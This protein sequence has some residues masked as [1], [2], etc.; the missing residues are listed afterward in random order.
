M[1][2]TEDRIRLLANGYTPLPLK[3]KRCFLSEWSRLPVTSDTVQAWSRLH[4]SNATG[5][6]VE[7]GLVAVDI[8]FNDADLTEEL[9]DRLPQ[10]LW[11][12]I[13]AAMGVRSSGAPGRE[14]WLLRRRG[15]GRLS[16]GASLTALVKD[17]TAKV[18][19]FTGEHGRQVGAL[20]WHTE[21]ERRYAWTQNSPLDTPLARLP[22]VDQAD[23]DAVV[24]TANRLLK[25][26]GTVIVDQHDGG[27]VQRTLPTGRV[28]Q[29][30]RFGL[31]DLKT[32]SELAYDHEQVRLSASWLEGRRAV[33]LTRCIAYAG[34]SGLEGDVRVYETSSGTIYLPN[35]ERIDEEIERRR[36]RPEDG[37]ERLAAI[38]APPDEGSEPATDATPVLLVDDGDLPGQ[39]DAVG[40]VLAA[41][42]RF[43]QQ[44]GQVV[45]VDETGGVMPVTGPRLGLEAARRMTFVARKRNRTLR[46]DPPAG[47]VAALAASADVWAPALRATV[48]APLAVWRDGRAVPLT[49]T[50]G[51]DPETRL[52]LALPVG[53]SQIPPVGAADVAAAVGELLEPFAEFPAVSRGTLLA[54]V[55]TAVCRPGLDTAP[56]IC[57]DAPSPGSGKTL[58]ATCLAALAGSGPQA[59]QTLQSGG[60]DDAEIDKRLLA[61]GRS[62]APAAIYDN[63]TGV[64]NAAPL[65]AYVTSPRYTG[66]PLG[67]SVMA[68]VDTAQL[69]ILT[70]NNMTLGLDLARRAVL[71]RLDSG[72]ERPTGRSFSMRP[73]EF[74]VEHRE[75]L[76]RVATGL[77]CGPWRRRRGTVRSFATW[78]HLIGAAVVELAERWPDLGLSDPYETVAE[79][80]AEADG[81]ADACDLLHALRVRFGDSR[82]TSADVYKAAA[83]Q[84]DPSLRDALEGLAPSLSAKGIGRALRWRRDVVASGLVLRQQRAVGSSSMWRVEPVGERAEGQVVSLARKSPG[85]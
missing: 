47:L 32:L 69:L 6:R 67:T 9:V 48:T 74:I 41:T 23:L 70:G 66:R 20:G 83:L 77:L 64:I 24:A 25:E 35:D 43:Y 21:N 1:N 2:L 60:R 55:L 72:L 46:V 7:G 14:L 51:Y 75:R 84:G 45:L 38:L 4:W 16:D 40:A 31:V 68:T 53:R 44:G 11:D 62:G 71:V 58:L 39:V 76:C 30:E 49:G 12:R 85:A 8:D 79:V 80:E 42:R 82:F 18:E 28:Y 3:G 57:V 27:G 52:Y 73:L 10:A 5:L 19:V 54:A 15:R 22:E 34:T 13:G 26:R 36:Q 37:A 59:V 56:L 29:T 17:N 65:A 61:L 33:N 81:V 50:T 78:D 63:L